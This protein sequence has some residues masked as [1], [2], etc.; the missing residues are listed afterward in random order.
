M[1][2]YN[3]LFNSHIQYIESSLR[4]THSCC[5]M[6]IQ[7]TA[8]QDSLSKKAV[9]LPVFSAVDIVQVVPS[10]LNSRQ[11]LRVNSAAGQ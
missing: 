4:K 8:E 10:H 3:F 6:F 2:A 1:I 7:D 9:S 11:P 5:K